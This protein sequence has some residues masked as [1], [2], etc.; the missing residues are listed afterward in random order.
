MKRAVHLIALT[1]LAAAL[2]TA[3]ASA[4]VF[5]PQTSATMTPRSTSLCGWVTVAT[6]YLYQ[7]NTCTGEVR[8]LPH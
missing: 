2:G 1:A 4:Q 8:I 3:G 6:P 5:R 7:K